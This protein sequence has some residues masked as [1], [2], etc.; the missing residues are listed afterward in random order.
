MSRRKQS[1]IAWNWKQRLL[2]AVT[3]LAGLG[4]LGL[5][6]FEEGWIHVNSPSE[7]E[8]PVR[9]VDVSHYQGT[10]DW[11][12]LASQNLTFA[13]I[14]AT[15]GSGLQDECFL[16]NWEGARAAGLA[17]GAYHFFSFDSPGETQAD[18]FIRTVPAAENALPPV[19]DVELYGDK[20]RNLPD[21]DETAAILDVLVER[22]TETY[23]TAP[24]FYTTE[25]CYR[26]Y[27]EERYPDS[28]VWI[29]SVYGKPWLS[30]WCFWQYFDRERLEGYSG[31]EKFIDMN[32][33]RG[34]LEE[35]YAQF[36]LMG[37]QTAMRKELQA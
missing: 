25:Q 34:S 24:I 27:I 5:W 16:Q 2:A 15:E 26:L 4:A 14:K 36:G 11:Q 18:N 22:L 23:G 35:F 19:I 10:I 20:T 33:Y 13:F 8:Y 3:A 9:G 21:A 31:E 17:A 29:R 28:P 6:L 7:T 1:R 37:F 12:V 30:D 32:V